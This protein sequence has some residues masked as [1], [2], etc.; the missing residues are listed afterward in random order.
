MNNPAGRAFVLFLSLLA[1]AMTFER[2]HARVAEAARAVEAVWQPQKLS[3]QFRADG[4]MFSCTSLRQKVE[5]ILLKV[6]AR[7]QTMVRHIDCNE[8]SRI[9]RID[10]LLESPVEATEENVRRITQFDS[11]EQLVARVRGEKLPTAMD[12]ERFPA[13]WKEVSLSKDSR[14]GLNRGDCALLQQLR[15]Y[16][17]PRLSVQIIKD[18]ARCTTMFVRGPTPRFKVMAL[19]P[20]TPPDAVLTALPGEYR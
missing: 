5:R 13:V 10:I 12:I 20:D 3:F 15:T 14:I 6:G 19:V 1:A 4:V 18:D 16:V 2:A 7:A 11:R 9:V 17:L 8:L